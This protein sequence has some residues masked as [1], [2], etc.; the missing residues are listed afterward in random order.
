MFDY[1]LLEALLA[2]EREGSFENAAQAMGIS[3]SAISQ[4]IGLLEQRLG[5]PVL[6]RNPARPTAFGRSLCRHFERVRLLESVLSI[7][8]GHH[9]DT[10]RIETASLKVAVDDDMPTRC[11]L[12]TLEPVADDHRNLLFD[13]SIR[14]NGDTIDSLQNGDAAAA[15]STANTSSILSPQT[16]DI[17]T[18]ELGSLT[19]IAVASPEF[20]ANALLDGIRQEALIQARCASYD[21]DNDL[22]VRFASELL[23]MSIGKP[24]Y[25]IPSTHGLRTLV[26]DGC[27]WAVLPSHL[28]RQHLVTGRLVDLCPGQ[29]LQIELFWHISTYLDELPLNIT[30][31]VKRAVERLGSV[32]KPGNPAA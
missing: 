17:Q 10:K 31:T 8:H 30:D 14:K 27:A 28:V 29:S 6:E 2:I 32:G 24:T 12:N 11:L 20:A 1:P 4:K 25:T 7:E 19:F 9:F 21:A 22:N 26:L 3:K 23:G 15:I 13:I 16:R 5:A 18:H